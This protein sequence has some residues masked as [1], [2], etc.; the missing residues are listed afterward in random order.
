MS[1]NDARVDELCVRVAGI[2]TTLLEHRQRMGSI[3]QRTNGIHVGAVALSTD[4]LAAEIAVLAVRVAALR[5]RVAGAGAAVP[6]GMEGGGGAGHGGTATGGGAATGT[7]SSLSPAP[8]PTAPGTP[9]FLIAAMYHFVSLPDYRELRE[10]YVQWCKSHDIR[11]TLLLVRN[12]FSTRFCTRAYY[13]WTHD[14][15]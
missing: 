3:V 15:V 8:A 4:R 10:T 14:I 1:S 12:S 9:A 6:T 11:G 13:H 5:P 7:P 2:C